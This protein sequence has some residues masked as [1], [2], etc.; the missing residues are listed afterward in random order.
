[1]KLSAF[2]AI[3]MIIAVAAKRLDIS[4]ADWNSEQ[5]GNDTFNQ[6]GYQQSTSLSSNAN[7]ASQSAQSQSNDSTN[8]GSGSLG[9][10]QGLDANTNAGDSNQWEQ[11]NNNRWSQSSNNNN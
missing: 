4:H 6:S 5:T 9:R 3:V 10:N 8:S 1:M 2:V 11:S 7:N